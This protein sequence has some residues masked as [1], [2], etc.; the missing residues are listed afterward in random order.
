MA[1]DPSPSFLI[2]ANFAAEIRSM[3]WHNLRNLNPRVR[4]VYLTKSSVSLDITETDIKVID[5]TSEE[6][7]PAAERTTRDGILC[8]A[9]TA[10]QTNGT[11]P[12]GKTSDSQTLLWRVFAA[13]EP[14]YVYHNGLV[15]LNVEILLPVLQ[16]LRQT[17][18]ALDVSPTPASP[19]ILKPNDY[20]VLHLLATHM[21]ETGYPTRLAVL[22]FFPILQ[23]GTE[24][25]MTPLRWFVASLSD[26]TIVVPHLATPFPPYRCAARERA[27]IRALPP[28][29]QVVQLP[30]LPNGIT[31][32]PADTP[33]RLLKF[34]DVYGTGRTHD[35]SSKET[36]TGWFRSVCQLPRGHLGWSHFLVLDNN[37]PVGCYSHFRPEKWPTVQLADLTVLPTLRGRGLGTSLVEHALQTAGGG[38][39]VLS[40]AEKAVGLY[41][42]MGWKERWVNELWAC[43][44]E[45]HAWDG[46]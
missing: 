1:P 9:T 19:F 30:E 36:S 20:H 16:R 37:L 2:A 25:D 14:D 13:D 31:V 10:E 5:V 33:Q 12:N 22:W 41:E 34:A 8:G 29:D 15:D 38:W 24:V 44:P 6:S 21:H 17:I 23:D 27:M 32:V 28:P 45:G 35:G 3:P 7:D 46:Q 39:L 43:W 40:A 26:G 18:E 42:R 11:T 4:E